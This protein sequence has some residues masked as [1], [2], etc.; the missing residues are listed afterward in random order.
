[1]PSSLPSFGALSYLS[2]I[3]LSFI[4][5][6]GR[7]YPRGAIICAQGGL[8]VT[9]EVLFLALR[10]ASRLAI[11][12]PLGCALRRTGDPEAALWLAAALSNVKRGVVAVVMWDAEIA[13]PAFR[14][15]LGS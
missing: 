3:V 8:Y 4:F 12:G 9:G 10:D 11:R 6:S 2:A 14:A 1:V 5:Q 7:R 13:R 15:Y